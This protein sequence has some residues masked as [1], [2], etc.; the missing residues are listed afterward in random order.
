MAPIIQGVIEV[1]TLIGASPVV[2][3]G[4]AVLSRLSTPY[5]ATVDLDLVD[6]LRAGAP[7]LQVLRAAQ[8]AQSV[9]PA[10]VLLETVYGPVKIDVLEVRQVEID[11]P[12]DDPGDRL[13]APAHAWAHDTATDLTLEVIRREGRELRVTTPSPSRG[14]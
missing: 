4:L 3:G 6:H 11:K 8:G 5:R 1:R 7:H 14:P 12:S 13:H 10:A 2:V 9:E